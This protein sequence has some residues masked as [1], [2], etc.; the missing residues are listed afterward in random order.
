[1]YSSILCTFKKATRQARTGPEVAAGKGARGDPYRVD[2]GAC[3][4]KQHN[5][6]PQQRTPGVTA[7][8]VR[9]HTAPL[10]NKYVAKKGIVAMRKLIRVSESKNTPKF[11]ADF[12]RECGHFAAELGSRG[13][14]PQGGA[15]SLFPPFE[16]FT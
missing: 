2:G 6:R 8:A 13:F 9:V 3:E 1:M 12:P 16:G 11:H 10:E 4:R 15:L 14:I 7:A 5:L